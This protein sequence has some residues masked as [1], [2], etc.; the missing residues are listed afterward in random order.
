M[1]S[2]RSHSK[3]GQ[4]QAQAPKPGAAHPPTPGPSRHGPNSPPCTASSLPCRE[5]TGLQLLSPFFSLS[6]LGREPTGV[7]VLSFFSLALCYDFSM[8]TGSGRGGNK[9]IWNSERYQISIIKCLVTQQEEGGKGEDRY[10]A[11][12]FLYLFLVPPPFA[13]S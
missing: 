12:P 8:E 1:L 3:A 4:S 6:P 11:V 10:K 5:G 13:P 7:G 9:D 2:L